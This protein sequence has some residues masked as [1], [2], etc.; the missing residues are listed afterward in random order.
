MSAELRHSSLIDY[1]LLG[2]SK[3]AYP[4]WGERFACKIYKVLGSSKFT[5]LFMKEKKEDPSPICLLFLSRGCRFLQ[6]DHQK[7]NEIKSTVE[8]G[9]AGMEILQIMEALSVKRH[10]KNK[11]PPSQ[12]LQ[13]CLNPWVTQVH[14]NAWWS[15]QN[16]PH[17]QVLSRTFFQDLIEKC[18]FVWR[19]P[20]CRGLDSVYGM[21]ALKRVIYAKIAKC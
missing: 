13:M 17:L 10:K 11:N 7:S 4:Q 3:K 18:N 2:Y 19:K 6:N 9:N 15:K 16:L 20:G 14:W 1:V 12:V 8:T 21:P 5:S